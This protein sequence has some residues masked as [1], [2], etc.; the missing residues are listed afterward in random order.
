LQANTSDIS[1][2]LLKKLNIPG[3]GYLDGSSFDQD[4]LTSSIKWTYDISSLLYGAD[5]L[6]VP[7][8]TLNKQ[9]Y[10]TCVDF[11]LASGDIIRMT[12]YLYYLDNVESQQSINDYVDCSA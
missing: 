12:L 4:V 9:E 6:Q 7:S 2:V 1:K 3:I 10:T 8:N 5:Y 11:D